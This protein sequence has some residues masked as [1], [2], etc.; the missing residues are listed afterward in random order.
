MSELR[1]QL[2]N[3]YHT[4]KRDLP[5]RVEVNDNGHRDPYHVWLS[6]I[7]LQ[8]TTVRHAT[9]YF[10]KFIKLWPDIEVLADAS[11]EAVMREWAG[12]GYYSRARNLH[13][14]AKLIREQ[15]G[16]PQTA[17]EL[18]KLP[19][20]GP[21]TSAAIMAF[22]FQKK[23]EVVVDGNI[24]RIASRLWKIEAS[25][26]ELTAISADKYRA[27]FAQKRP[28]DFAEALMD[29]GSLICL[30]KNPK[31]EI[32]PISRQCK[33][34]IAHEVELYPKRP[35]KKKKPHKYGDTFI[36]MRQGRVLCERRP[37]KGL[38]GGML[39]L[40]HSPWCEHTLKG[41]EQAM[42]SFINPRETEFLGEVEHVFTHF[43]LTQKVFLYTLQV[44]AAILPPGNSYHWQHIKNDMI[45]GLP[46]V[47]QKAIALMVNTKSGR[48]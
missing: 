20:I 29:L 37:D 33:A 18:R 5:W 15:G 22:A 2:L 13:K 10:L 16:W 1:H 19:G 35:A 36:C 12:L 17:K 44:E 23:D 38:L 14:T 7:M 26:P 32:C 11:H 24:E 6:E 34:K 41:S 47:F 8:Q 9:P 39:G 40:P 25:K 46:S 48:I 45:E 42:P 27:H 43:K 4:H 3:W 28:G 30:P 31:C 21:Y